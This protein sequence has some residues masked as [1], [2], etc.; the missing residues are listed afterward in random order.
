[1]LQKKKI[2]LTE[3]KNYLS[4]IMPSFMIPAY[5]VMMEKIPLTP[6]G[7]ID[8][9]SLPEP[10]IDIKHTEL[11]ADEKL[12][13]TEEKLVEIWKRVLG[14]ENI[15]KNDSFFDLGGHSIKALRLLSQI[16][17]ELNSNC[18]LSDIFEFPTVALLA[19][20]IGKQNNKE[21]ITLTPS[22]KSRLL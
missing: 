9:D 6:N 20:I 21:V 11:I 14:V 15:S 16:N 3:L 13:S 1:M 18:I 7:K 22:Y 19:N 17:N 5:F 2:D 8:V 12:N 4:S 10:E